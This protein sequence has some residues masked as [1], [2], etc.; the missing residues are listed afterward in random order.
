MSNDAPDP[1]FAYRAALPIST[2]AT[3]RS[4]ILQDERLNRGLVGSTVVAAAQET[5]IRVRSVRV[6]AS[7]PDALATF[8]KKA[9][10]M[11]ETRRPADTATFRAGDVT[12]VAP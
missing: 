3:K 5:G 2:L 1:Q 4:Q 12:Q 7:D 10:G 11:S 6:L 9:F 8:Y